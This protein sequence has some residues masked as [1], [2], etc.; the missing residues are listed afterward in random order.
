LKKNFIKIIQLLKFRKPNR[1]D[2]LKENVAL[3]RTINGNPLLN[4]NE[5]EKHFSMLNDA[6]N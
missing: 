2:V 6:W 1:V 3:P 5:F 4:S